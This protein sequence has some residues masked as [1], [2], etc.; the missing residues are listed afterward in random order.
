MTTGDLC[1]KRPR[2]VME[3]C[4]DCLPIS[5]RINRLHIAQSHASVDRNEVLQC[6]KT[7]YSPAEAQQPQSPHQMMGDGHCGGSSHV[8]LTNHHGENISVQTTNEIQQ[9][10]QEYLPELN[11]QENPLYFHINHHNDSV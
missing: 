11:E 6:Q 3:E 5:K 10:Q 8:V 1:R 7:Y 9:Q 2:N 4:D